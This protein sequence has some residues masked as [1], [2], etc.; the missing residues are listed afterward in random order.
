MGELKNIGPVTARQLAEIGITSEQEL[1]EMG[2]LEAYRRL[3]RTFP[4]QIT[5]VC[6]YALQGALFDCHW[7]ELP[8]DVKEHLRQV[9]SR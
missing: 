6:L 9:G 3:K 2:A 8:P 4:Q 5:L 7:N 1:R